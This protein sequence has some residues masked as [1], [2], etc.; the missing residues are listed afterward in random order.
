ML[1]VSLV[2]NG[3]LWYRVETARNDAIFNAGVAE[4]I[5]MYWGESEAE[6]DYE[7]GVLRWYQFDN[8][9]GVPKDKSD[10]QIMTVDLALTPTY[11]H[12]GI[13]AFVDSYNRTIDKLIAKKDALPLRKRWKR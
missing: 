3:V 6:R 12:R 5:G 1:I 13:F 8:S 9:G 11:L 7:S 2:T 4:V 10:R